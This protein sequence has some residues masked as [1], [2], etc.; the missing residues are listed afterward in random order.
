MTLEKT[1]LYFREYATKVLKEQTD[2]VSEFDN[3]NYLSGKLARL[4]F[5]NAHLRELKEQLATKKEQLLS[6]HSSA[7]FYNDLKENLESVKQ[8]YVNEYMYIGFTKNK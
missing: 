2:H 6:E 8:E 5:V 1:I 3:N 7:P 4:R